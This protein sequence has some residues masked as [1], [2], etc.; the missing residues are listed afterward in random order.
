MEFYKEIKLKRTQVGD[1]PKEWDVVRL[2]EIVK[3]KGIYYGI[4]AKAIEKET[5]LRMLRTTDI[6]NYCTSWDAL[7]FCQVTEKRNDLTKYSLKKGDLIVTRAGTTGM[8]VLVDRDQENIIFG[9]YLIKIKLKSGIYPKFIQYFFQSNFYWTYITS[10]Q[11]GSTLKNINL[12]T[13]K[14]LNIPLPKKIEEQQKIASILSAVDEAIQKTD[15]I[16]QKTQGLKKGLMQELLSKGIGH[17]KFKKTR[18]GEISEKWGVVRLGDESKKEA[19]II[20]GQSPPGKTYNNVGDGLP[21]LQGKT[22]FGDIYPKPII[23]TSKPI[24]IAEKNDIL[25]S[26]RAPVGEVN[27]SPFK[28]CIG[29]GL[30]AIRCNPRS[31]YSNFVFYYLKHVVRRLLIMAT[32]STFGAIKKKNLSNFLIPLPS[33]REQQKIGEILSFVDEKIEKE[34][35]TKEQLEKLKKGF[36][37][38]LLTGK[39]RVK[40]N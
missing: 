25:I 22:E 38:V 32:G 3:D 8:S 7:P 16:I 18:I 9:S 14:S 20:M 29:R 28:C 40:L 36:M 27:L 6:K 39:I 33:L 5:K 15:E 13:L 21:F 12:P 10:H 34:K 1:I 11:A 31:L 2:G 23:Y 19:E 37:Q 4:T 24:K 26:V 35:Q 30:A 17:K